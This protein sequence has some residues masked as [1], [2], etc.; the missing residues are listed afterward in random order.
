MT[1]HDSPHLL[2]I[3]EERLLNGGQNP[4]EPGPGVL[5]ADDFYEIGCSGRLYDRTETLRHLSQEAHHKC[6][7]R[8]FQ[9]RFL[10]PGVA[11]T[12]YLVESAEDE[13]VAAPSWRSS[14]WR[15]Q[16]DRWQVHFHQGTRAAMQTEDP[17]T[18]L[19]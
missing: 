14:L 12:V 4:E 5:L 13:P 8:D 19:P 7:I 17:T 18:F 16:H 15:C 10:G 1:H 11:L 3:L 9:V 6:A 2:R